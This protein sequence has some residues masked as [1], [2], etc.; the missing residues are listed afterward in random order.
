MPRRSRVLLGLTWI[1]I[2]TFALFGAAVSADDVYP[3]GPVPSAGQ[4]LDRAVSFVR[5]Q[6]YPPYLSY[7]VTVRAYAKGRWLVEQFQSVCRTRDDRVLTYGTPVSTTNQP[8][9]P[10]KFTLKVKGLAIHDSHNIDEPFGLPEL[11]PIYA[12][13]LLQMHP[14]SSPLRD[15]DATLVGVETLNGHNVYH[16]ALVP[17]AQPKTFRVRD[18]WV[19]V[20]TSAIWQLTS[21]GAF[22]SGPATGVPWTVTFAMNRGHWLID[23]EETTTPLVLGGY[24]PALNQYVPVPGATRY[25]DVSYTFL[26]VEFPKSVGDYVFLENKP[27]QAVQ[28]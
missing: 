16:L 11:S 2:V 9:N 14:A 18:L 6:S 21:A 19:D 24:A 13:G 10:Y 8:D 23:S 22:S 28:M 17:R 25:D 12:F 20:R 5:A 3:D 26:N 7:I 4:I 1:S 27:S 15:Y